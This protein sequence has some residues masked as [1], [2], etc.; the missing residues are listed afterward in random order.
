MPP[1]SAQSGDPT[2]ID[3]PQA[4]L[5]RATQIRLRRCPR[6][7][8]AGARAA[9]SSGPT[10]SPAL[11]PP[12]GTASSAVSR[13]RGTR[14]APAAHGSTGSTWRL[15]SARPPPTPPPP[16]RARPYARAVHPAVGVGHVTLVACLGR[17]PAAAAMLQGRAGQAL[18]L[19]VASCVVTRVR[20]GCPSS[21][22]SRGSPPVG[23][24]SF[25][26]GTSDSHRWRS[27][28]RGGAAPGR[29]H[30]GRG[31]FFPPKSRGRQSKV[32]KSQHTE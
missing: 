26:A 30:S 3:L 23:S 18:S 16:R 31:G 11:R 29:G 24:L 21:P 15:T 5:R 14:T 22:S 17:F 25:Q 10:G 4:D 12:A 1:Q 9:R 27:Q 6:R 20:G 2:S 13:S 7:V 28:G 8:R 32:F 19:A